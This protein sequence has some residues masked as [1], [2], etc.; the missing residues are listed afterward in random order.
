[1]QSSPEPA[2][3]QKAPKSSRQVNGAVSKLGD[4]RQRLSRF[5]IP[6]LEARKVEDVTKGM[7]T[8]DESTQKRY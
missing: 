8:L 2:A 1:M 4:D 3:S 5:W 6:S 7:H